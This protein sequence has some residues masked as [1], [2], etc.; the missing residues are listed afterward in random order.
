[1]KNDNY[2]LKKRN[3]GKK[4]NMFITNKTVGL[5][6]NKESCVTNR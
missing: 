1:M 4:E 6:E 2:N 5:T 3:E